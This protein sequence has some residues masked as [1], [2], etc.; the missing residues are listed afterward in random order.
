MQLEEEKKELEKQR[1][2]KKQQKVQL[3]REKEESGSERRIAA[4]FKRV[5]KQSSEE[6]EV[7]QIMSDNL[8]EPEPEKEKKRPWRKTRKVVDSSCSSDDDD[9]EDQIIQS[10]MNSSC[11]RTA[12]MSEDSSDWSS[13]DGSS[14]EDSLVGL[15][16]LNPNDFENVGY[17]E[18]SCSPK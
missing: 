6:S 1:E 7:E 16:G 14:D 15:I 18:S 10:S 4:G 17:S 5:R 3:K 9:D 8:L 2:Q 12:R 13:R 11:Q